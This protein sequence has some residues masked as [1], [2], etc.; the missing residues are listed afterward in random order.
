MTF[1]VAA[2]QQPSLDRQME[3]SADNVIR[4]MEEAA[5]LGADMLLLPEAFLTGYALPMTNDEALTEDSPCLQRVC[6]AA[7]RL[8][9]GVVATA[10]TR[11]HEK[12]RNTAFVVNRQGEIILRYD[13]VH[14]CAFADEI[15]L[16]PGEAFRV[17]DFDGIRL[18][19]MICYDREYP[20]SARV[21][22]LRGAE[23]IL[24]PNDC[25]AMAPR[26]NALSTRAYENMVGVVMAN[27]CGENAGCSCAFSPIC[28]DAEG[29]PV[30]NVLMMADEYSEGLYLAAFD[31]DALR[32]WREQEM[33]GNTFRRV[34]AYGPL[35][36]GNVNAPFERV[37]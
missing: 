24:V 9:L 4:R 37:K 32:A 17:C 6:A 30:D 34:E 1:T 21:L 23:I 2:L 7:K 5:A 19:V 26:L 12:P 31:M 15:C 28:W 3:R 8:G 11:G 13:K 16:E 29:R 18:G 25:A 22:M 36:D 33:M 27:P 10:I 14:T 35:L 20:E